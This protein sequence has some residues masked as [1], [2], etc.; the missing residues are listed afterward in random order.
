MA[1][2]SSTKTAEVTFYIKGPDEWGSLIRTLGL[3]EA[4]QNRY[5]EWGEYATVEL[6]FD[7]ELMVVRGK[8]LPRKRG[9]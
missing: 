4:Q 5:F 9:R 8:L 2:T 7:E 1:N 6:E 3:T